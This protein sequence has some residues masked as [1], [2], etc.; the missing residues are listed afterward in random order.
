MSEMLLVAGVVLLVVLLALTIALLVR[1]PRF[2]VTPLEG[3]LRA[4]ELGQERN[5]RSL[6]EELA[7]A[8]TESA[9]LNSGLRD[10]VGAAIARLGDSLLTGMGQV[11]DVQTDRLGA[12]ATELRESK[13]SGEESGRGLRREVLGSLQ[14]LNESLLRQF[15]QFAL[16]QREQLKA[17]ATQLGS[18]TETSDRKLESVRAAVE[19]RLRALQEDNAARLE[20]VRVTVDER[21]QGTLEARL[22]ESFRTVSERL[23]QVHR[24]LGEMQALASGVGDL[25]RVLSNVKTRG[26]WGE[27]QLGALLEQV[28][29]PGQFER[30]VATKEGSSDRVE[31][32]I[33]LPGRE[34]SGDVVWLPIDAKFPQE[35]YQRLIDASERGDVDGVEQAGR[36]LE[37][38]V[39]ASAHEIREKYLD[40]P[41]TTD[42]AILFLPTEGL[43]AEVL[44]RPGL[45]DE[46]QR[47]A[48]IVVAGPTTIWAILNSLQMGFRSLAIEKRSSEVWAVL[49]TVKTQFGKF[50]ELLQGVQKKL[51]EASNKIDAVARQSRTIQKKLSDV[52]ELPAGEGGVLP[53]LG[54][55][56]ALD[57]PDPDDEPT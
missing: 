16:T 57:L 39:T 1:A 7:R 19:E 38:R 53:D 33:R 25:K 28:L 22:G 34:G 10:E 23:E 44:R 21:L 52:Q 30:N 9:S 40:P 51:Q 18:L 55:A 29:A 27:V 35:D 48:R 36:Q 32:A 54:L 45:A 50:G 14:A 42:F 11:A 12:F 56:P 2:D 8:R 31:F 46:L 43:Y 47:S 17:F 49:G 15:D 4:L 13:E 5:D 37:V 24:G 41:R 3:R 6:Q 20:Q 26:T